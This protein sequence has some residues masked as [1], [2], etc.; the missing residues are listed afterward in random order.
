M[1]QSSDANLRRGNENG[2]LKFE[3]EGAATSDHLAPLCG[4]RW[5]NTTNRMRDGNYPRV[6]SGRAI[7]GAVTTGGLAVCAASSLIS[8][9]ASAAMLSGAW[10]T[11][12]SSAQR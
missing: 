3:S 7:T 12:R 6:V 5:R 8:R 1:M 2:C 10:S 4:E 9:S 11:S